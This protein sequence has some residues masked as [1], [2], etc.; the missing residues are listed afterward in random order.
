MNYVDGYQ[1][2]RVAVRSEEH[3]PAFKSMHTTTT[4]DVRMRQNT[5]A[6]LPSPALHITPIGAALAEK[7][8]LAARPPP[9]GGARRGDNHVSG[10]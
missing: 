4:T 1:H 6:G 2:W 5:Q 10:R 8:V 7:R 3:L 9:K